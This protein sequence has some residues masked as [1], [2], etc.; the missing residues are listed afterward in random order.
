M[1]AFVAS[2][3]AAV[4]ADG[5]DIACDGNYSADKYKGAKMQMYANADIIDSAQL[6][7]TMQDLADG[8]TSLVGE[9]FV[10]NG[11]D[12]GAG[13]V[14]FTSEA[15]NMTGAQV[16]NLLDSF[17]NTAKA[18]VQFDGGAAVSAVVQ[19]GAGAFQ[20]V[21][22]GVAGGTKVLIYDIGVKVADNTLGAFAKF[23]YDDGN[24][25]VWMAEVVNFANNSVKFVMKAS[26]Q[27]VASA[28]LTGYASTY[29]LACVADAVLTTAW[30]GLTDEVPSAMAKDAK[31]AAKAFWKFWKS[32]VVEEMKDDQ[33]R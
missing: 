18:A 1:S 33:R 32:G 24:G 13:V 2:A 31:K 28:A 14:N 3:N 27:V 29:E 17:A 19:G 22:L 15:V 7:Q 16:E 21:A 11:A 25:W 5:Q 6:S 10:A 8:Q 4:T 12:A 9:I 30:D 23:L 20:I 26:Y